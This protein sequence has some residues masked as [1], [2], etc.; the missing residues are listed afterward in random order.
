MK[1]KTLAELDEAYGVPNVPFVVEAWKAEDTGVDPL[2][3]RQVNLDMMDRLLPG[4]NNVTRHVRVYTVMTWAWWKAGRLLSGDGERGVWSKEVREYVER[5]DAVFS[6]SQFLIDPQATLPGNTVLPGKLNAPGAPV[7]YDFSDEAWDNLRKSR[8]NSTDLLGAIQYGPSIR[9]A[10]GLRWLTASEDVFVPTKEVMP[11]IEAFDTLVSPHLPRCLK[12]PT[13]TSITREE[14]LGI[15]PICDHRKPTDV[16]R[17]VF[18]LRF[19]G[20]EELERKEILL[21]RRRAT[22]R[23]MLEALASADEP[24][25]VETVRARMFGV[26]AS[27][28][29]D[30]AVER[31]RHGWRVLQIRQLQR[32]AIEALYIATEARLADAS[33]TTSEIV[34]MFTELLEQ[35]DVDVSGNADR[36]LETAFAE[37]SEDPERAVF[38]LM[39]MLEDQQRT[40]PSAI[41]RLSLAA[42]ACVRRLALAEQQN[43]AG[44]A[45]MQDFDRESDRLPL[46]LMLDR[47]AELGDR[48]ATEALR[49]FVEAWVF[50]QHLRWSV[51]RSGDGKQRLR[52]GLDE[53]GW[54]L[55]RGDL[56]ATFGATPDRLRS[57]LRLL[58]DAGLIR[59]VGPDLW[60]AGDGSA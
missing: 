24:C 30:A 16:E 26:D 59:A 51:I 28:S 5:V 33:A 20:N 39:S 37:W 46:S 31:A 7:A 43:A 18:A 38:T 47:L 54:T 9:G 12:D 23:L 2:G 10:G 19:F 42:L 53:G 56:S 21:G 50:G 45:F 60:V 52:V 4:I 40:D 34:D 41:P 8:R 27:Q 11:A 58:A 3:L 22:L 36:M 35:D 25:S 32:L 49:E 44:V 55:L 15:A 17:K 48:P 13:W 57:A 6:W 1:T 29:S 14:L